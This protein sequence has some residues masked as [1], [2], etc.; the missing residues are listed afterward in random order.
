[1]SAL[2]D[3]S[4][5]LKNAGLND[6]EITALLAKFLEEEAEDYLECMKL[7][8]GNPLTALLEVYYAAYGLFIQ[9]P[10]NENDMFWINPKRETEIPLEERKS[11]ILDKIIKLQSYD[12]D[13][14]EDCSEYLNNPNYDR[15]G[16]PLICA[17][18]N[19][20]P[21]ILEYLINNGYR[22]LLYEPTTPG[23]YSETVAETIVNSV[24]DLKKE[25]TLSN[26]LDNSIVEDTLNRI[27][28]LTNYR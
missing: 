1:M 20:D 15:L 13:F 23:Y 28:E 8:K 17:G 2:L 11:G 7:A 25:A 19:F 24:Y 12:F 9:S 21:Y 6:D 10:Y 16:N 22:E 26:N 4:N 14:N 3:L 18:T 5:H 27:I